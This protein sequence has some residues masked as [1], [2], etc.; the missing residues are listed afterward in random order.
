MKIKSIASGKTYTIE[1]GGRMACFTRPEMK[2]E[3][4]S[5][6]VITP[7]AA[8]AI[9]EA[10]YW[11]P[12]IRWRVLQIDVLSPIAFTHIRRCEVASMAST[13]K[14]HIIA[15]NHRQLRS[16]LVLRDVCYRLTAQ[17]EVLPTSS[18]IEALNT[19]KKHFAIFERRASRGQCFTQPY[20]GC[21]EF[22]ANWTLVD[23]SES[24]TPIAESRDLGMILYDMD[25][26]NPENPTPKF[27]RA[28]MNN[29]TINLPVL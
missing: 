7:S 9:F 27:F 8:R 21:R 25:F 29:G 10:I 2:V 22:S 12:E 15:E 11:K 18:N 16:S 23:D 17:M 24:Y 4:V 26:S 19:P 5:Y 14:E 6:E 28:L 20:L 1:A 3:R 13:K